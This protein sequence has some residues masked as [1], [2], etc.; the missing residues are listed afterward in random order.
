MAH[1]FW[2]LEPRN[3]IGYLPIVYLGTNLSL[4]YVVVQHYLH[5]F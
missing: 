1:T 5:G 2:R 4:F 3:I